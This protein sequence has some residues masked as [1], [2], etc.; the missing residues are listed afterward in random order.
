MGLDILAYRH[1]VK[2][3]AVFDEDDNWTPL[4]PVSRQPI[5]D[6]L[7]FMAVVDERA[8]THALPLIHRGVYRASE[9]HGFRAGS[10]SGYNWW[11]NE[12]AKMAGYAAREHRGETSYCLDCWEGQ[13][14]PFSELI[15]FSDC[16]GTIGSE[17]GAK[18]A[19]DFAEF[20]AQ[21]QAL[22]EEFHEAYRDWRK[23][24]EMAADNGAVI[25]C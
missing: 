9:D 14:G 22:G 20:D 17:Y 10:Y 1:A 3:E 4:D 16:E 25:F 12:L 24:F 2:I 7:V 15:N 19:R 8:A 21:A 23:A 5:E 13:T 18:L 11:R 6:G